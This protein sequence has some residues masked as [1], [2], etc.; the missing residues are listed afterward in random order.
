M[1]PVLRLVLNLQ[2]KIKIDALAGSVALS[3]IFTIALLYSTLELPYMANKTLMEFFPDYGHHWQEAKEFIN[4]IR[5]F[6]Y[7]C[8]IST[9]ALI[10]LGFILKKAHLSVLGSIA[11][12]LP[13]FGYFAST[14]FF[15]AGIGMLRIVWLPVLELAPGPWPQK[16]HNI[17]YILELGD[18]VYIPCDMIRHIVMGLSGYTL[19]ERVFDQ[20]LFD[21]L[22][23]SGST[24]F[25]LGCVAWFYGKFNGIRLVDFWIYRYS[26]HP[27]Y[28][29]FIIWSY[30]LLIYDRF[31]FVPV[32]GGYFPS[33]PL[34][35][36]IATLIII[37]I[38]LREE[39]WLR[40]RYG[41]AY[42][43]YCEKT[44]FMLPMPSLVSKLIAAPVKLIFRKPYP[45][46]NREVAVALAI[47]GSILI[48]TSIPYS[49]TIS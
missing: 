41:E 20:V 36:L 30:G 26:R 9:V 37:G 8:F 12:Y 42:T 29:G 38:A 40:E 39:A 35:W 48:L 15:L 7:A 14:M 19:F 13:T 43:K 22:I 16:P 5:P 45:E 17:A 18:S 47:Y 25:F 11:L 2:K 21:A 3:A 28:L 34:F 1:L 23:Y 10:V 6:G 49:G 27:Q 4:L 44:P 46:R 33:P 32:K 24:V 31:I